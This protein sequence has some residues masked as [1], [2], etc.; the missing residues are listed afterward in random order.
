MSSTKPDSYLNLSEGGVTEL[1]LDEFSI[2]FWKNGANL[3]QREIRILTSN[4]KIIEFFRTQLSEFLIS[5]NNQSM[6]FKYEELCIVEVPYVYKGSAF[7]RI[8]GSSEEV[9]RIYDLFKGNFQEVKSS[10]EWIYNKSG[11]SIVL[12]SNDYDYPCTEFY[13]FLRDKTLEEYYDSFMNSRSSILIL[14]G[15]PGTGKT[16]FLRGLIQ[17]TNSSAMISYDPEILANDNFFAN[18]IGSRNDSMQLLI[19][20]DADNLLIPRKE[21]NMLMMKFLNVGDG[22]VSCSNKKIVFTTNLPSITEIDS[23]L[24]RPGRCYDILQFDK[25][26]ADQANQVAEKVNVE[27][28]FTQNTSL[29]EVFNSKPFSSQTKTRSVGFI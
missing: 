17:H 22:L 20:E 9:N 24:I 5:Q 28:T 3:F 4:E 11:D 23:A 8:Y 14:I 26:T 7:V 18:F 16:S 12:P 25:L 10:I 6:L 21:G 1:F 29:A 19:L 15:P 13:P 27:P 2:K